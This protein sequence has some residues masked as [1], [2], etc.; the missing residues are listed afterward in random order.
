M[1]CRGTF[2]AHL[3]VDADSDERRAAFA[4]LCGELGVKCV[5]IELARGA[6]RSQPMTS[7]HH[8]GEV[9]MIAAEIGALRDRLAGAG[10]TVTRVK[11]EAD[12]TN[13]GIPVEHA[14]PHGTYFEFHAK[15]RVGDDVEALRELCVG[16]GAHLSAN[17]IERGARFVTLRVY[18][19]GRDRA[20]TQFSR[21]VETLVGAGHEVLS[22][23]AELTLYD[24]RVELDAGWLP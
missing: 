22:T 6:H 23:K 7:S 21:L 17:N 18:E 10:F 5:L 2:E 1:P 9:A 16:S 8:A 13:E 24:S 12:V 15:L 14:G 4:A 11:I 20:Q 19:A 3:T